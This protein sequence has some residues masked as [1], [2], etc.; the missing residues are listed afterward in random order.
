MKDDLIKRVAAGKIDSVFEEIEKIQPQLEEHLQDAVALLAGDYKN[1]LRAKL[2]GILTDAQVESKSKEIRS[3]LIE[4]IRR[5]PEQRK[6]QNGGLSIWLIF[7]IVVIVGGGVL[8]W[9]YYRDPAPVSPNVKELP[10]TVVE[11]S[12]GKPENAKTKDKKPSTQKPGGG[13]A[14]EIARPGDCLL[15]NAKESEINGFRARL[16][17]IRKKE[18]CLIFTVRISKGSDDHFEICARQP[19]WVCEM[20]DNNNKRY[21]ATIITAGEQSSSRCVNIQYVKELPYIEVEIQFDPVEQKPERIARL[22]V[23]ATFGNFVF[24]DISIK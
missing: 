8:L 12:V 17:C 6:K 14:D 11:K 13:A 16:A 20:I 18:D 5:L 19:P 24:T 15:K 21:V 2:G 9:H 22:N 1:F 3:R 4:I 7:F 23:P 10:E